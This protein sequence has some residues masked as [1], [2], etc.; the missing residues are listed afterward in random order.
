MNDSLE[1]KKLFDPFN[2]NFHANPYPFYN[3]LREI[4]PVHKCYLGV[5]VLT[6][7]HD[8]KMTLR[9]KRFHAD[10]VPE[11]IYQK[12]V[13]Y[14]NDA[15]KHL[16][17]LSRKW[18]FFLDPPE[19]SRYRKLLSK[20]FTANALETLRVK[21]S[22]TV[23]QLIRDIKPKGKMDILN[24]FALHLPVI[25]ICQLIGLPLKDYKTLNRWANS[26]SYILD[27]LLP[28][29]M[30]QKM[31]DAAIAFDTYLRKIIQQRKIEP[32]S[33]LISALIAQTTEENYMTDDELVAIF[34]VIFITGEETVVNLISN[35]MLS[36]LKSKQQFELLKS[37]PTL[38][39]SAVE[40]LVRFD[41][42]L[43]YTARVAKE[44]IIIRDRIIKPNDT[45][46]VSLGAA[47][48]DPEIFDNPN[49]LDIQ[50]DNLKHVGFGGG[51][52]NCLG[53]TLA[54]IQTQIAINGLIQQLDKLSLISDDLAW[55]PYIALRRL[56][57]LPVKFQ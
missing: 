20:F 35:G 24:D 55:S 32:Q 7:Y 40:E 34:I 15:I 51:I 56:K 43:Q 13:I 5:W 28:I 1:G 17:I 19:H 57:K 36:L 44:E 23:D 29:E 22:D 30:Y 52:H 10:N 53:L 41:S 9:D 46:L 54:R 31:A 21:I 48:R 45:V 25:T 6:K 26:L 39:N 3:R 4:D 27:P 38:I 18:I 47:N 37:H 16:A 11:R 42:P 50:R 8:V 12:G 14:N 33:D 49:C 2:S